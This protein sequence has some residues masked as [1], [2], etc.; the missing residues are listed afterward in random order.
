KTYDSVRDAKEGISTYIQWYNY[1]R[2]HTG[3]NKHRLYEVMIGKK[4]ALKWA[5]SKADGYV[6]NYKKLSHIPTAST[7]GT[8]GQIYIEKKVNLS[9][10]ITA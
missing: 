3:I 7:T 6:D 9:S 2:R 10:E 4:N 1:E 5:F 8:I